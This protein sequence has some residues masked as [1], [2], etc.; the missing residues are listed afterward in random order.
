[1]AHGIYRHFRG[2]SLSRSYRSRFVGLVYQDLSHLRV[3]CRFILR[4]IQEEQ[5][6]KGDLLPSENELIRMILSSESIFFFR[7]S[8]EFRIKFSSTCS[9]SPFL[10][11]IQRPLS[12][13]ALEKK[14]KNVKYIAGLLRKID[15][16][17]LARDIC[18][19]M[20][21]DLR[22]FIKELAGAEGA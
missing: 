14:S 21:S 10:A 13:E 12:K 18:E 4:K 11:E 2:I 16:Q 19:A 9:S 22:K 1:M 17:Q 20:D 7:L 15:E 8:T 6:K 5:I 3:T